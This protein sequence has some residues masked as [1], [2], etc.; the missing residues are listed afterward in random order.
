MELYDICMLVVLVGTTVFGAWKGM[1]WQV[2]SSASLVA[3]LRRVRCGSA[4]NWP[5]TSASRRR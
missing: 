2:A 4:R 5:P 1:A 3:Q